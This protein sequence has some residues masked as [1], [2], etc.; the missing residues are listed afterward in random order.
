MPTMPLRFPGSHGEMDARLDSPD[1]P[2]R[3]F[4]LFAH[5]FT[6]SKESKAAAFVSQALALQGIATL[7]FDFS[8]PEFSSNLDDL[9]AAAQWLRAHQRAPDIL[10]GHSLGGTAVLAAA[11]RIPEAR[12]VATIGAPFHPA[13]VTH[14]LTDALPQIAATG[15]AQVDL[16]AGPVRVSR[17]FLDDLAGRD[18]AQVIGALRKALLVMHA[19]RDSVV[20][21]ENASRIFSAAKHPKS[22]VSLDDADHLLTRR[23]DAQYAATVLAAWASRYLDPEPPA[24]QPTSTGVRVAES[25]EGRFT[26]T[27][28]A[29]RHRLRADEPMAVGGDDAGPS[30]YE[31]LLAALGAC[32]SMTVRMYAERKQWPLERV[33]VQLEHARIHASDCAECET[34]QA[35]VDRIERV[36]TLDGPLDAEQ[37]QRLLEIANKCPVH[38]TLLG[39]VQIPTR[40]TPNTQE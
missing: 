17:P 35:Y 12:A 30:P 28:L 5:C 22:F 2:P 33:S 10:I 29:G 13:H 19:P 9:V 23:A 16:G 6:C 34:K 39:E 1:G 14:L 20:D 36:L 21:I 31:L 24:R 32:T 27:V 7:R 25:G 3:A 37:R 15:E 38:R 11:A 40:L 4:A 18:P 26:Q 8:A